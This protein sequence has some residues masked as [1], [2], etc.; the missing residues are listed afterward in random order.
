M[1]PGVQAAVAHTMISSRSLLLYSITAT[2]LH[3]TERV[4]IAT[5]VEFALERPVALIAPGGPAA[6][7]ARAQGIPTYTYRSRLHKLRLFLRLGLR[8]TQIRFVT[9]SV[10]DTYLYSFARLVMLRSPWHVHVVHGSG[11]PERSYVSKKYLRWMPVSIYAVSEYTRSRLCD[12]SGLDRDRVG[13]IENFVIDEG[14][15]HRATRG[16]YRADEVI[17][18][19]ILISR[20]EKPKRVDLLLDA[21]ERIPGLAESFVFEIYGSGPESEA[22]SERARLDGLLDRRVFF[23]GFQPDVARRVANFDVFLHLCPVEPFGIVYLEAMAAGVISVGPDEGSQVI[24]DGET[25]FLFGAEDIHSLAETLLRI[26]KANADSLNAI[27]D[28]AHD[29][30]ATRYSKSRALSQYRAAIERA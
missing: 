4:A 9:I 28:Q 11:F 10:V 14:G 25:G 7:F 5:L 12:F 27:V 22:L 2:N 13:V 21:L 18:R 3:G 17:E 23:R 30:L 16:R 19:V 15:T 24:I 26:K 29:V 8:N 1:L 20:L 6:E